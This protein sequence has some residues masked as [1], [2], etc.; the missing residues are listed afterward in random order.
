[1]VACFAWRLGQGWKRNGI[2]AHPIYFSRWLGYAVSE[3]SG[4]RSLVQ[5]TGDSG[6][7]LLTRLGIH[8]HFARLSA[9]RY[10]RFSIAIQIAVLDF[11]IVDSMFENV[12]GGITD[13]HGHDDD[14]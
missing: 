11:T 6:L 12:R 1:M 14:E 7:Y 10:R 2:Y 5:R 3:K 8:S 9:E 4:H 13:V